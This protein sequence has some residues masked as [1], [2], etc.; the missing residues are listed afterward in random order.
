MSNAPAQPVWSYWLTEDI[1]NAEEGR[2][3][4]DLACTE[5]ARPG[6]TRAVLAPG[7]AGRDR[8][9]YGAA[10]AVANL[11]DG[12][13][14]QACAQL[15]DAVTQLP[16]TSSRRCNDMLRVLTRDLLASRLT[17]RHREVAEA[18]GLALTGSPEAV[19]A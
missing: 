2:G 10:L 7:A 19:L 5:R 13:V 8:V 14:D 15:Q 6:L 12:E 18:A 3:W 17:A 1:L 11:A 4:I 9:L 16:S